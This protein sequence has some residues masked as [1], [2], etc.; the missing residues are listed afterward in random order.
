MGP[1]NVLHGLD[2]FLQKLVEPLARA[3]ELPHLPANFP[4]LAYSALGF[5]FVHVVVAPI[6]SGI[7]APKS[8][9]ALKGRR[10]RNNWCGV[11]ILAVV[12]SLNSG[13]QEHPY[14]VIRQCCSGSRACCA[15]AAPASVDQGS[16]VW[17]DSGR[18]NCER[19]R[20]G[21]L[22]LGYYRCDRQ[23]YRPRVR[24]PWY[25]VYGHLYHYL[26]ASYSRQSIDPPDTDLRLGTLFPVLLMSLFAVGAVRLVPRFF[27]SIPEQIPGAP[28]S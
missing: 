18:G 12:I 3:L 9:G 22:P 15:C 11:A 5:T 6:L 16:G 17:L 13:A 20:V 7:V 21:L 19:S 1:R 25:G 2:N 10:A 24:T 8:Y 28:H 4:L 23:L 14:R 26:R 27:A